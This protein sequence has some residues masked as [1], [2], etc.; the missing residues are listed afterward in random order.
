MENL[1]AYIV[2]PA[3]DVFL[4]Y[5]YDALF[6]A[7]MLYDASGEPFHNQMGADCRKLRGTGTVRDDDEQD[8]YITT[9]YLDASCGVL[10]NSP[11]FQMGRAN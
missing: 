1:I 9:F 10:A 8:Y 5:S 4:R 3:A 7:K 11:C 2:Q 6:R